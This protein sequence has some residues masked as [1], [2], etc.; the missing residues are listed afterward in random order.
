MKNKTKLYSGVAAL[1]LSLSLYSCKSQTD[2]PVAL[3]DEPTSTMEVEPT[4]KIYEIPTPIEDEGATYS[5]DNLYVVTLEDPEADEIIKFV[6]TLEDFWIPSR[7][8]SKILATGDFGMTELIK[9]MDNAEA[10][11]AITKYASPL[12]DSVIYTNTLTTLHDYTKN[13]TFGYHSISTLEFT[14]HSYRLETKYAVTENK[15]TL[16]FVG[17]LKKVNDEPWTIMSAY[18]YT[19]SKR[20]SDI[21]HFEEGTRLSLSEIEELQTSLNEQH[22]KDDGRTLR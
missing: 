6:V 1:L 4:E 2:E 11:I 12:D 9:Y 10:G 8:E 16:N 13:L 18:T 3:S 22:T 21:R 17:N 15:I 5:P 14:G 19:S 7:L 20:L